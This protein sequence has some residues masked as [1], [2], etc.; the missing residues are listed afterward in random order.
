VAATVTVYVPAEVVDG[1]IIDSVDVLDSSGSIVSEDGSR[2]AFKPDGADGV[3]ETVPLNPL[4]DATLIKEDPE[5]P[6]R[7]DKAEGDDEI[8]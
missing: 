7:I 8:A 5:D 3:S 4:S 2:A 6:A 1:A